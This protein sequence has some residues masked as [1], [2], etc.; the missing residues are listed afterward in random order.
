MAMTVNPTAATFRP[1]TQA[2]DGVPRRRFTVDDFYRMAA[3]GILARDERIELIGGEI[4]A[5][6]PKGRHHEVVRTELARFWTRQSS[7]SIKVDAETPLRLSD[8]TEPLPDIIA[9]PANLV[10]PDVRGDTVLLVVEIADSSLAYDSTT[11][12]EVY[13]ASGV[14]E[15]WVV[16]AKRRI[17]KVH[18][19]PEADGYAVTFKVGA[20][21][22]AVPE[23]APELAVTLGELASG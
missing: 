2:A 16:D 4:V 5:M 22:Q 15:Y 19:E 9:Y 20:N 18:R 12:A 11:K 7:Q 17:V 21:E 23:H 13:A 10:A 14:R 3:T 8:D 6:S 1:P